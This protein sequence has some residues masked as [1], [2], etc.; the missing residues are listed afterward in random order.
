M[1]DT[2]RFAI[3]VTILFFYALIYMQLVVFKKNSKAIRLTSY[4]FI[5]VCTSAFGVVSYFDGLPKL[6]ASY[7]L[8]TFPISILLFVLSKYKDFRFI[9]TFLFLDTVTMIFTFFVSALRLEFGNVAGIIGGVILVMGMLALVCF[10][11][12]IFKAYRSLVAGVSKEWGSMALVTFMVYLLLPVFAFY[13]RSLFSRQEYLPAY[14]FLCVTVLVF[15]WVFF[16]SVFQK[17]ELSDL[18]KRLTDEK[19]WHQIAYVDVLTGMKNRMAYMEKV[20]ELERRG[21]T[22]QAIHVAMLDLNNFKMINDT[23]GHHVGDQVLKSA[24]ETFRTTFS[25]SNY[26][27]YRIGGDEFAIF[28][29][30][31][32][33]EVLKERVS[34]LYKVERE[35]EIG[36]FV[37]AGFDTI[38]FDQNN[39]VENALIRAD[40]AMYEEKMKHK[41]SRK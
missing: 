19:K 13:P 38:C 24:A 9:V 4:V 6:L 8:V 15:Y 12:N 18:N 1:I 10:G 41:G 36:L 22:G 2:V 17:R 39:A 29:E 3:Q 25:E 31:V 5:A 40:H 7:L 34:S 26:S 30:G 11:K 27:C 23:L 21:D 37:A 16:I 28:A 14:A 20:G 32:P 33:L 35:F